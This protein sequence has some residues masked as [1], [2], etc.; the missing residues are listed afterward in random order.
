MT[1]FP[2][3]EWTSSELGPLRRCGAKRAFDVHLTPTEWHGLEIFVRHPNK[4]ISQRQLLKEVR[5]PGY[6]TETNYLRLYVAQLRRKLE[7]EPWQP[8][9]LITEAGMG[10]RFLPGGS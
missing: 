3:P 10:Y 1:T 8:R 9:Y 4:L 2:L 7:P 6:E 5:G